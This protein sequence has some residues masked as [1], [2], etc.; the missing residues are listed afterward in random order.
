MPT[1]CDDAR[2]AVA[3]ARRLAQKWQNLQFALG[4][5]T[6]VFIV[7]LIVFVAADV[8]ALSV[9]SGALSLATGVAATSLNRTVRYWHNQLLKQIREYLKECKGAVVPAGG[10]DD[11]AETFAPL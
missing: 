1:A 11:L 5:A 4:V 6:V 3:D 8:V 2:D 10:P 9:A 7:V